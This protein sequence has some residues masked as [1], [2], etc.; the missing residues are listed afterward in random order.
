MKIHTLGILLAASL[1]ACSGE[2]A[3]GRT[4]HTRV[5]LT[6]APFPYD[7]IARVDVHIVRVQVAASADTLNPQ[8]WTT[9][10]EPRRTINLL[11]LQSGQTT[12]LGETEVDAASVGAVRVVINTALSSVSDNAGHPVTVH[13]PLQGELSIHSY[14]QGSLASFAPGTPQNLVIDFDVG[15]SFE[16]V[17]GDGS[18]TFIPWIRALDDAGAGAV[19][20][21][22]RGPDG[23]VASSVA[24][25]VL[26]GDDKASPN[27]WWKIATGKTDAQ[28]RYKVSYILQGTYIVRA[29]PLGS[30]PTLGCVDKTGIIVSNGETAAL[31]ISLPGAPGSCA[32]FTS[33]GGGP[34]STG[35]GG[36]GNG[37]GGETGG[38]VAA[39]TVTIWPASPAVGDST[40]AYANLANS[41]GAALYNRAV[42]WTV[43]DPSILEIKG[44][45]GQSV[46]LKAKAAGTTTLTA[47]SEGITGSRSVT[48]H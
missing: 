3:V 11:D 19:A 29:E 35:T 17:L 12:L 21:T 38:P 8:A 48:V 34:D 40:G 30:A 32:R 15:R 28:G 2:T 18:L 22:V 20:G 10:V 23:S 46:L 7:R 9:L 24:V 27:T 25:T 33:G 41:S 13:W 42:T 1:G 47:T 16:D 39:V 45:F 14:V 37:G 31:D 44:Q 6:D 26:A 4:G 5:L 43:G 36:G